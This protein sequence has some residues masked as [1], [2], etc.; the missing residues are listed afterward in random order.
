MVLLLAMWVLQLQPRQVSMHRPRR[1]P[2]PRWLPWYLRVVGERGMGNGNS[3]R[4]RWKEGFTKEAEAELPSPALPLALQVVLI[5]NG[6]LGPR[7]HCEP[8][9]E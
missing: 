7:R 4:M 1:V 5:S 9:E 3:A 2:E 8:R 6:G